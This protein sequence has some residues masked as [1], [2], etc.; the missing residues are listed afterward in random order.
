MVILLLSCLSSFPFRDMPDNP[1]DDYDNDG[2]T[3]VDGDCDD[4]EATAHVGEDE[5]CGDGIDNNCNG[6][7]DESSA[8]DAQTWYGDADGDGFGLEAYNIKSCTQPEGYV[9]LAGDCDDSVASINPDAIETCTEEDD[10]CDGLINEEDDD[11]SSQ[12]PVYYLDGDRDS[13]GR[14][15]MTQ[16][17]CD[18]PEGYVL[19]SGD[20]NDLDASIHPNADELCDE[21]DNDCDGFLDDADEGVVPDR[22]WVVDQ[23]NDGFGDAN[24]DAD[25]LIQCSA[26]DGY[27]G[28]SDDCNDEDGSINPNAAETCD[29]T[30]QDCDGVLDDGVETIFYFDADEDGYG[31][32]FATSSAC[33][34][35]VGY[36]SNNSDCD[37]ASTSVY[38]GAPEL[39]EDGIDL[40][41][42]GVDDAIDNDC[43]G[44]A[45]EDDA[46][47]V[48]T[49]YADSDLD[50]FGD[51]SRPLASCS[52]PYRY[53]LD[54]T[55]CDDVRASRNPSVEEDCQTTYDDNCDQDTNDE[56]ALGC[57][58]YYSDS[59]GDGHGALS[60]DSGCFCEED[61]LYRALIADD[62]DDSDPLIRPTAQESCETAY[63][64]N[65]DGEE[66]TIGAL[67]CTYF[68]LDNDGDGF[69]QDTEFQCTCDPHLNYTSIIDGDCDDS[70]PNINPSAIEVCDN[71]IDN[72]CDTF[73]DDATA[74]DAL[75]WH[76][77]RDGDGFG[78]AVAQTFFDG[79]ITPMLQCLPP[80]DYVDNNADCDDLYSN[81]NPDGVETCLTAY[82]DNCDGNNNDDGA[83]T[84]IM[85]YADE[86]GDAF[87]TSDERCFC[88]DE[89]I[90]T[91][92]N[93]E[94][95]NDTEA[96]SNP[97]MTE[98]C[99]TNYD[100]N[101]DGDINEEDSDD[102]TFYFYDFDGD[103]YGQP[104]YECLCGPS[105]YYTATVT[106]DCYDYDSSVTQSN[107]YCGLVGEIPTSVADHPIFAANIGST[108]TNVDFNGDQLMDVIMAA[109]KY[110]TPYTDGGRIYI[111]LAPFP[112]AFAFGDGSNADIVI[113]GEGYNL[114]LGSEISAGDFDGD[115]KDELYATGG[116]QYYYTDS[117]FPIHLFSYDDITSGFY[118]E[119]D[120]SLTFSGNGSSGISR[121]PL[122]IGDVN[123]DGFDD[124]VYRNSFAA[125]TISLGHPDV[126]N[127]GPNPTEDPTVNDLIEIWGY[128]DD[129]SRSHSR[130]RAWD[131]DGDGITDMLNDSVPAYITLGDESGVFDTVESIAMNAGSTY[132]Y[133][134]VHRVK[135]FDGDGYGDVLHINDHGT[136]SVVDPITGPGNLYS[137]FAR[138]YSGGSGAIT[139]FEDT[140]LSVYSDWGGF[141]D[142]ASDIGDVNNDGKS[143]VVIS[144][145]ERDH[146]NTTT[147]D[148]Q[149]LTLW[150]G[151]GH[152][153]TIMNT[154]ADG[155]F[156]RP[157]SSWSG[158]G[159]DEDP[160]HALKLGDVSGDGVDDVYYVHNQVSVNYTT[161]AYLFY[162]GT[163]TP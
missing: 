77:D 95:C 53:V 76:I 112:S 111:F 147:G 91:A 33:T 148:S 9:A 97:D 144:Y 150:Y 37:D 87:G 16:S 99:A 17:Q 159:C 1:N 40:N 85:F 78:E 94:D 56:N 26:P 103:G 123:N 74:A 163:N 48:P 154:D 22:V 134:T 20:C 59:D 49:W 10:D 14:L 146:S 83:L 88:E 55:D 93:D 145:R 156:I 90:Y 66:N 71:L 117:S 158:W 151:G 50:G 69:G 62:C 113:S 155:Y 42:D 68:F 105:G 143:E 29:G 104:S 152:S 21:L 12:L 27:A 28:N 73:I 161:S 19:D 92:R 41:G 125:N 133:G 52:Q 11:F 130:L 127:N 43:D 38:P 122:N 47:D 129:T 79:Q 34:A 23:D 128:T 15:D 2:Q 57:L 6:E 31:S 114:Q 45:D 153:G 44:F 96:G 132:S 51:V 81:V 142:M 36:V 24:V 118:T 100:D 86:D 124:M 54:N 160:A 8:I 13:W 131:W 138:F 30:D 89:G 70:E 39:C 162:G 108:I 58:L 60:Q 110:D 149:C 119:A 80:I 32:P 116:G 63:D 101:C 3:E 65:C 61:F 102:C 72:N 120:A 67:G 126:L 46:D 75:A 135:D 18:R 137:G 141:G 35:P 107:G 139:D 82:D 64:D 25:V 136:L 98:I 4:M 5:I 7:V 121:I 157:G 115:G 106:G 84:C 140:L 109:D